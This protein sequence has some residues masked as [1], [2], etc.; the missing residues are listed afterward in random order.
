MNIIENE[1]YNPTKFDRKMIYFAKIIALRSGVKGK[2]GSIIVN[3]N[4]KIESIGV[5]YHN[6]KGHLGPRSSVHAESAA[7]NNINNKELFTYKLYVARSTRSCIGHTFSKP[8]ERCMEEILNRKIGKIIYSN[9][10]LND[11]CSPKMVEINI[12]YNC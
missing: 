3:S 5:N 6:P 4:E 7:L 11:W 12:V 8:C 1:F 10:G 9:G 2:H